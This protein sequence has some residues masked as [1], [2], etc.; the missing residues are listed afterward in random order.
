MF[1]VFLSAI[2]HAPWLPCFVTDQ[3]R[4]AFAPPHRTDRHDRP[5]GGV[6]MYI[7][8]FFYM[9]AQGRL[10]NTWARSCLV[11]SSRPI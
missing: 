10:R 7:R 2:S 6:A 3:I 5:S 1:E 9:Q 8:D 4:L 11:G